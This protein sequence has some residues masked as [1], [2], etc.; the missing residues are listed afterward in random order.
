VQTRAAVVREHGGPFLVETVELAE[1]RPDEV[2]VRI[3]SAGICHT[4]LGARAGYVP[5]PLPA[6]LGHEGAGV[7]ERVGPAVTRV[8]P[9][10]HVVL[11]WTWCGA[12]PACRAGEL[13]CCES[14][15]PINIANGSRPDG[16]ATIHDG[17]GEPVH[18]HWFA[19]SSFAE[20]ALAPERSVVRVRDDVPLAI[21]GP[22]GCG[23][24]TGAGAVMNT[25]APRPGSSIAIFGA[26]MV[27]MSAMLAALVCGCTTVIVVDLVAAR[28]D[29][30]LELGATH[31]VNA[32]EVDPVAAIRAITGGGPEFTLECVGSPAVLRQ[33][34]D[35]L[36]RRGICGLLGVTAP[37]TPVTLDMDLLMNARTVKG[38]IEGDA[39]PDLFIPRLLDL[40]VQGRFPFDR[41]I[42]YFPFDRINDAVAAM[43]QGRVIKPVLRP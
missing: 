36:P 41:L 30:A 32:A 13:T 27:G 26:G 17:N 40:Y 29:L 21:L 28:L 2:V 11:S 19:Q 6:V 7:V 38:I 15:F 8:Q 10:D 25:L 23:I 12:C 20:R 24:Q 5:M 1:P 3:E 14:F 16:S 37:G 22:L 33:A 31:V 35:V 39:V 34:V 42:E 43:E 9:G 4:D 18:G